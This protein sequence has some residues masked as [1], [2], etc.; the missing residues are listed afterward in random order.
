MS[1]K[2]ATGCIM[3][4]GLHGANWSLFKK[5]LHVPGLYIGGFDENNFLFNISSNMLP[6]KR[7]L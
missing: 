3:G 1:G 5:K 2:F 4:N 7:S 6:V